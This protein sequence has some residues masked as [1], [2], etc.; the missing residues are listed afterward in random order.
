MYKAILKKN[1]PYIV[2]GILLSVISS[3]IYVFAGYSLSFLLQNY[4]ENVKLDV[5]LG[6]GI[7]VFLIWVAALAVYPLLGAL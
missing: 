6:N 4:S 1:R 7:K 3:A 2:I 5:L